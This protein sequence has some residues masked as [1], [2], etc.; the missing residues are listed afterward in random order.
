MARY[1]VPTIYKDGTKQLTKLNNKLYAI[2]LYL[3]GKK[4]KDIIKSVWVYDYAKCSII[5]DSRIDDID[6]PKFQSILKEDL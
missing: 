1:G 4:H 2:Q 5:L 3:L 6:L